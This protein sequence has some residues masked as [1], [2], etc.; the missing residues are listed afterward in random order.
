MEIDPVGVRPK[1]IVTIRCKLMMETPPNAT[2]RRPYYPLIDFIRLICALMVVLFHFCWASSSPGLAELILG[3]DFVVPGGAIFRYGWVGVEIFFVISGFVIAESALNSTPMNFAIRRAERLYPAVWICAPISAAIWLI[4]G[5]DTVLIAK[6]FLKSMLLIPGGNWIDAP[7]WTLACEIG[8]YAAIF[9]C[10][11]L[12]RPSMFDVSLWISFISAG[13]WFLY[14]L[15]NH[16]LLNIPG[17]GV[18]ASLKPI[19]IYYGC[20]FAM[21]ML[22]YFAKQKPLN[23][24]G[25][26]CLGLCFVAGFLEASQLGVS[27]AKFSLAPALIWLVGAL[28]IATA[29]PAL[30]VAPVARKAGLVTYPLYLVHFALGLATMKLVTLAGGSPWFAVAIAVVVVLGVS[31]LIIQYEAWMRPRLRRGFEAAWAAIAR[32]AKPPRSA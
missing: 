30:R 18:P 1:P 3:P 15:S 17:I 21:G 31:F 23:L 11:A 13:F 14:A 32:L 29:K 27:M 19:P 22:L 25:K 8:F 2:A 4:I 28:L 9:A 10:L 16:H 20:Y 24:L 12:K 6:L 26:V 5:R 7:Y